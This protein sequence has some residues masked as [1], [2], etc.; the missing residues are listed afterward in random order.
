MVTV[1]LN[2]LGSHKKQCRGGCTT[3]PALFK[4]LVALYAHHSRTLFT[5]S[6]Q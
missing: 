1:E 4:L 2:H 3:T 5:Y 6:V